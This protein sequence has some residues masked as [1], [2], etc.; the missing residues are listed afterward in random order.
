MIMERT[1]DVPKG[2][3]VK[4]DNFK[5][6]VKGQKGTLEKNFMSP[7]F[8]KDIVMKM[9]DNKISI[10]TQAKKR[11]IKAMIGTI[12]SHI[13]NMF[14]GVQEGY[15]AKLK[16]VFMHFP[17]TIKVSGKEVSINNFLGEKTPRKARVIGD[18]KVEVQ[19]DEI[20]I[21]GINKDDVGQTAS[22]LERATWIKQRD[23]RVFQDGL[24]IIKKP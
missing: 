20:I 18:C 11:K 14:L 24:F 16:V 17:F 15:S 9:E 1:I 8:R 7:L 4:I 10:S 5:V 2:I 22:Q 13:N 6:N 19:G 21:T 3:E 23:R 12:E